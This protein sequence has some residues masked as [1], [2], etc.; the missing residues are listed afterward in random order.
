[1]EIGKY[2]GFAIRKSE[3]KRRGPKDSE[4]IVMR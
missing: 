2:K 4:I 3:V 1:M